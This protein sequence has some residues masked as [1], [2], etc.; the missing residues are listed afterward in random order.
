MSQF[1]I[2][3]VLYTS[4]DDSHQPQPVIGYFYSPDTS[5]SIICSLINLSFDHL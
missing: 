5:F 2:I 1:G 4:R 3:C